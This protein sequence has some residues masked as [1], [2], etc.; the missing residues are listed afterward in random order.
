M[1]RLGKAAQPLQDA[2]FSPRE[3]VVDGGGSRLLKHF[4][5]HIHVDFQVDVSGVDVRV[6]QP[7]ADHVD[8]ISC[9]QQMHGSRMTDDMRANALA[10][11]RGARVLRFGGIFADDVANAETGDAGAIGVEE[12]LLEVRDFRG[13]LL[14]ISLQGLGR[15]WP[16]RTAPMLLAFAQ[17]LDLGGLV[18]PQIGH[19]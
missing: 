18:Q 10:G 8:L 11:K 9:P 14:E 3:C 16:E 1:R 5:L 15:F 19:V 6:A 2:G 13:T 7:V 4:S 17:K 12:E